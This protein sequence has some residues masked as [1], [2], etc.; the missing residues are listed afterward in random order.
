MVHMYATQLDFGANE[1]AQVDLVVHEIAT[2]AV[3]YA[4]GGGTL[5]YT[6]TIGTPTGLELFYCDSGP[7][8]YD[9]DRVIRDGVSTGSGLGSGLGAI[10]RLTDQF[11]IYSTVRVT[12]R[13]T[14][15]VARRSCHGTALLAR[16]WA[17]GAGVEINDETAL[18]NRIGV[19][20]RAHPAESANGDAY[21]I[22][23]RD[24]LALFAVVDG[25]GHGAGAKAAA[26]V[27]L[28]IL[29]SWM[30]ESL[31]D[32]MYRLHDSL[33]ATRGA[34][35]AV[36]EINREA[37]TLHYAGVGNIDTR[38]F[39]APEPVALVP[40]NGTL[41]AR[42]GRL[43]VRTGRWSPGTTIVMTSDGL[44][45]AWDISSY[46]GVL[47]RSPQLLAGLLMRDYARD[48]DDATVLVVK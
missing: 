15:G 48:N 39:N 5:H 12:T 11:E 1:L 34:V 42:L 23:F 28:Q 24:H 20:S 38:V 19:W 17:A 6:S 18:I 43:S 13:L 25:L 46:P 35:A 45:S 40:A 31:D 9:I 16:K 8:I 4:T 26:D 14:L 22:G 47:G 3:R 27:A 10:G 29:G 2:N 44:S 37:G 32:L 41:G 36:A 7:G 30:G 33:R 21:Y